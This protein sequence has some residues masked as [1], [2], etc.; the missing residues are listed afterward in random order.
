VKKEVVNS[1]SENSKKSEEMGPSQLREEKDAQRPN[2]KKN[3]SRRE[4]TRTLES[5]RTK[6]QGKRHA[7]S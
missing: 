6:L 5:E 1:S 4:E 3:A 7:P 2:A